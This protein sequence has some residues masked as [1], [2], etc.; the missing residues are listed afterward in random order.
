MPKIARF[1]RN[2]VTRRRRKLWES[3]EIDGIV[4][5]SGWINP[6]SL[7]ALYQE[8]ARFFDSPNKSNYRND[9]WGYVWG[10]VEDKPVHGCDREAFQ[11]LNPRDETMNSEQRR[12]LLGMK[13]MPK[14]EWPTY[15][16]FP[17]L[18]PLFTEL[19]DASLQLA[20]AVS[21]EVSATIMDLLKYHP[22]AEALYRIG[23]HEDPDYT[24]S[25][26]PVGEPL[27]VYSGEDYVPVPLKKGNVAV[28]R[29]G[30]HHRVQKLTPYARFALIFGYETS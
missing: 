27:E 30:V 6:A 1:G 3:L 20:A 10:Y 11:F 15:K 16:E 7:D 28:M 21:G 18:R 29:P 12:K 9:E 13:R 19:F 5:V 22:S 4:I 17:R 24:I 14:G 23:E 26:R 8:A 25:F 2:E